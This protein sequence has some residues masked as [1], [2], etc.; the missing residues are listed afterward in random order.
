MSAV[1]SKRSGKVPLSPSSLLAQAPCCCRHPHQ[2]L[3]TLV[4]GWEPPSWSELSKRFEQ[5]WSDH[6]I[7]AYFVGYLP[8]ALLCITHLVSTALLGVF[9]EAPTS[10]R[11]NLQLEL[12]AVMA[13][14]PCDSP[15]ASPLLLKVIREAMRWKAPMPVISRKVAEA[16]VEIDGIEVPKDTILLSACRAGG[17]APVWGVHSASFLPERWTREL[18]E[19]LSETTYAPFGQGARKCM[20]EESA[21]RVASV[22][23][24]TFVTRTNLHFSEAGEET[25]YAGVAHH[26]GTRFLAAPKKVNV[27]KEREQPTDSKEGQLHSLLGDMM[28]ITTPKIT[29]DGLVQNP[30]DPS[31]WDGSA[32]DELAGLPPLHELEAACGAG[33]TTE[34]YWLQGEATLTL[35]RE[36]TIMMKIMTPTR[37]RQD[38][39]FTLMMALVLGDRCVSNGVCDPPLLCLC[40]KICHR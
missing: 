23:V 20:G 27:E 17:S 28:K 13:A 14:S 25:C 1:T 2:L 10:T 21:T 29:I 33:D 37:H 30:L 31:R 3:P 18:N 24:A 5:G 15:L 19:T 9:R 12:E 39:T 8:H 26:Q 34:T 4:A 32:M 11:L 6:Q 16:G 38:D 7:A 22:M 35:P 40:Q 36:V